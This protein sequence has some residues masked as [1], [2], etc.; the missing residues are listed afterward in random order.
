MPSYSQSTS[1]GVYLNANY[2]IKGFAREDNDRSMLSI[3]VRL[4]PMQHDHEGRKTISP[5]LQD[6]LALHRTD[7]AHAEQ[8]H[9]GLYLIYE[10]AVSLV[11]RVLLRANHSSRYCLVP[12]LLNLYLRD[13]TSPDNEHPVHAS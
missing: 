2:K 8:T 12:C 11:V 13:G 5:S 9:S 10:S 3:G 6:S 7:G 1:A 4:F